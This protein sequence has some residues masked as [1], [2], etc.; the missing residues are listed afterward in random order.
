M[1]ITLFYRISAVV[2]KYWKVL[3]GAWDRG[4][5]NLDN[6]LTLEKCANVSQIGIT[7]TGMEVHFKYKK[8]FA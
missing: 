8:S 3:I 4:S 6:L 2:Y 7:D 5:T 1:R